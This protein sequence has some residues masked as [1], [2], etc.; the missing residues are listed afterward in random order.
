MSAI[1]V[2]AVCASAGLTDRWCL[3]TGKAIG[4]LRDAY[5]IARHR[6]KFARV[7]CVGG[8]H[9]KQRATSHDAKPVHSRDFGK[10]R[11]GR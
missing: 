4:L 10:I 8:L 7:Q 1:E 2:S 11:A 5:A 9:P 3:N 6:I